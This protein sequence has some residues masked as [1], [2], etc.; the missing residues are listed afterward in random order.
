MK[1]HFG[2][3]CRHC[4][5]PLDDVPV[6][7]CEGDSKKAIPLAYASL[8]V[9]WDR[10]EHCRV[11]FSDGRIEDRWNHISEHAP[12]YHFGYSDELKHPPR[13]DDKLRRSNP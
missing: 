7:A 2:D 5:I 1:T 9:R 13:F 12:Y 8:G 11:R 6:G 3:P 10:V 4:G